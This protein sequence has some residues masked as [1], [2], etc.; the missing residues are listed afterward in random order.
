MKIPDDSRTNHE[1]P[2]RAPPS[3]SDI[4][5]SPPVAWVQGLEDLVMIAGRELTL[6]ECVR[7]HDAIIHAWP[8]LPRAAVWGMFSW[9]IDEMPPERRRRRRRGRR[10]L[11]PWWPTSPLTP[12]VHSP[13]WCAALF[14]ALYDDDDSEGHADEGDVEEDA[15][16]DGQEGAAER[17]DRP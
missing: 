8:G 17:E 13:V 5:A 16:H 6:G 1:N 14:R 4:Y 10:K 12:H 15:G 7:L 9:P 3:E 11:P 2:R